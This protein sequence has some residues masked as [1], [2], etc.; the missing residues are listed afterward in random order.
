MKSRLLAMAA[1]MASVPSST[2]YADLSDP[3]Q[4]VPTNTGTGSIHVTRKRSSK[5]KISVAQCKRAARKRKNVLQ[6]RKLKNKKRK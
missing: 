3:V 4:L 1:L 2:H 6:H 5:R